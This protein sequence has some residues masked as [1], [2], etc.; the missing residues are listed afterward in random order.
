LS[1]GQ[2]T[3]WEPRQK[4]DLTQYTEKHEFAFDD[5]Y[6]EEVSL[7]QSSYGQLE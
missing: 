1:A 3:L 4:V 5:V 2:L 6:P 7:F